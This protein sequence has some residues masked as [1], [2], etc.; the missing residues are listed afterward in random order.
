MLKDK[1]DVALLDGNIVDPL[2]ANEDVAF[3]RHFQAGDHA[4]HG[5]LAA[6]A[7]AQQRRPTR[8]R[9]RRN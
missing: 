2:A 6:A 7:R 3:G 8:L 4:Q 5:R 9:S 1:T